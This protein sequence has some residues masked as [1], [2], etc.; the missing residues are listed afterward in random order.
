MDVSAIVEAEASKR[1]AVTV[2]KDIPI[3][4]DIGLLSA[5]D[6]NPVD[7]DAYNTDLEAHLQ[8]VARDGAQ[9]ILGALFGLPTQPSDDGPIATLPAPTTTLPRAKPLPK[10]KPPTKWERFAAAKGIQKTVR[11]RR[12]WDEE[13]Q[14]WVNRWGWNG[15]NKDQEEQWIHEVPDNAPDDYDPAMESRK[16]RKA[17]VDKNEKQKE[18]NLTMAAASS[19][20]EREEVKSKLNRTL[21][22][23]RTSTASMG[24][25][26]KKLDGDTKLKGIK[27]QFAPNEVSADSEKKSSM[28][29]IKRLDR[30]PP[31]SKR[32]RTDAEAED[33]RRTGKDGLVNVRKAIRHASKGSGGIALAK[34]LKKE[35]GT[36]KRKAGKGKR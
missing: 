19:Q 31:K 35:S 4:I 1:K 9:V 12:V 24:R 29:I 27:R 6:T 28:D 32:V 30:E 26:D 10:P 20:R 25:F 22:I 15:K 11:D 17:R 23:T 7:V 16:E 2:E 5:L 36:A 8:A 14:E 34:G 33:S 18:R 13:R 3:Q 21:A